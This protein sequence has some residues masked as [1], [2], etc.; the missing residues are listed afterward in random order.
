MAS[1]IGTK[2]NHMFRL[3][4]PKRF[5][6]SVPDYTTTNL[7]INRGDYNVLNSTHI[8]KFKEILG[9][10]RVLTKNTDL[11]RYNIDW[12]YKLR[13]NSMIVLKPK[14]TKEVSQILELCNKHSLAVCPQGGNTSV[15][16]GSVPVFDE[17]IVSTELMNN[18]ISLDETSGIL[19]CEAGCILENITN[20]VNK[21][22]LLIPLD[23]GSKGS[24]HIGGNISTNA[25]GLR[26]LRF[27]NL[28]RNVLGIEAV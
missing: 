9:E 23:L 27:G 22:D 3:C 28:H 11:E 4:V 6:S 16:G 21:T 10:E 5:L 15:V 17:I 24:C 7:R 25:G 18:I 12:F 2:F 8:F 26:I 13:G 1:V 20:F 14:T 19:V